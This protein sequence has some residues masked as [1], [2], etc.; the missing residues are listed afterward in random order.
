MIK[1]IYDGKDAFLWLPTD[2]GGPS[3]MRLPFVS[4]TSTVKVELV[5]V[6]S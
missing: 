5:V 2:L 4:T 1:C 6:V 3:A